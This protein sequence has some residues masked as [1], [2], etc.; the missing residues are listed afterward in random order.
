MARQPSLPVRKLALVSAE[1]ILQHRSSQSSAVCLDPDHRKVAYHYPTL[2]G[3]IAVQIVFVHS[4]LEKEEA[5]QYVGALVHRARASP[6]LDSQLQLLSTPTTVKSCSGTPSSQ[7]L[8][9]L[10]T[11]S[12]SQDV[13]SELNLDTS[14]CRRQQIEKIEAGEAG[15]CNTAGTSEM[16][17]VTWRPLPS[18]QPTKERFTQPRQVNT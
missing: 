1:S 10:H 9:C 16:E 11:C 18:R 4:R 5:G 15:F 8:M 17:N 3:I 2:S 13:A 7:R 14:A 12:S 6:D